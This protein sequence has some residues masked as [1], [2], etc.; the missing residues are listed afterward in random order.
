MQELYR[1]DLLQALGWAIADSLWQM[2]LLWLIYLLGVSLPFRKNPAVK[3]LGAVLTLLIG[4]GWF[5]YS[6][7]VRFA[8]E[9]ILDKSMTGISPELSFSLTSL[10]NSTLPYFSTAYLVILVLLFARLAYHFISTQKLKMELKPAIEWQHV[11]NRLTVSLGISREIF[12]YISEHI[13][14]P[15]T[16]GYLKPVI[17][18]PVATVN[19]LSVDQLEAVIIHEMAHIRRNDY[20]VNLIVAFIETI[21]FF[22]PFAHL[23]GRAIRKEC[24]LCCDDEVIRQQDPEAYAQALLLLEK[25][26]IS[27]ALAMAVTGK[28]GLLLGRV[29]R[30][31]N[32]PDQEVKYRHKILALV[33]LAGMIMLTGLLTPSRVSEQ[34]RE[35][36][37]VIAEQ[38]SLKEP[39]RAPLPFIINISPEPARTPEKPV[40]RT[41]KIK[42]VPQKQVEK[43]VDDFEFLYIPDAPPAPLA[44]TPPAHV[45]NENNSEGFSF[46]M[47]I[48]ISD[49]FQMIAGAPDPRDRRSPDIL[50]NNRVKV[51][52]EMTTASPRYYQ[53]LKNKAKQF[54]ELEKL[55]G[56]IARAGMH[57]ETFFRENE[58]NAMVESMFSAQGEKMAQEVQVEMKTMQG[59][60]MKQRAQVERKPAP[61]KKAARPVIRTVPADQG[62]TITIIQDEAQ[63]KIKVKDKRIFEALS[64]SAVRNR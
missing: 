47:P 36:T 30:I 57:P 12:I 61:E 16:I 25:A 13:N 39:E 62:M 42:P 49:E 1:S 60:K 23:L 50:R 10:L 40:A 53:I 55:E 32:I 17:L 19:Q 59:E 9:R 45:I 6:F 24:E 14:V 37:N 44:P 2:S 21:L 11:V 41:P 5:F 18:L 52:K 34:N 15:S 48:T 7:V 58:L 63:I 22:N 35:T 20:L 46:I 28:Q 54:E 3:H 51:A 26:K 43:T 56:T 4:T 38:V 29:K 8:E 33:M 27:P 31:L 64:G